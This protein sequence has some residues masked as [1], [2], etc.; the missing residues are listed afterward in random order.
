MVEDPNSYEVE[1]L[2]IEV[3]Y[4]LPGLITCVS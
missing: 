4:I 2:Y 1:Y 3:K